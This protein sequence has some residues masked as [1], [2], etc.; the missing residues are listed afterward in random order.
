MARGSELPGAVA[1][2]LDVARALVRR[3]PSAQIALAR[4]DGV[5][6]AD[7]LGT[8][9]AS[10]AAAARAATCVPLDIEVVR[11]ELRAAW[12]RP[13]DGVLGDLDPEPLAVRPA[14]Q[15]HRATFDGEPV[16]VKVRRPGIERAVRSDL[17]LLDTLAG[18]LRAA[19]PRLDAGAVLRM[20]RE[21]VLDEL[22]LE[23][24]GGQQRRVARALRD[25]PGV[26]VP[27][28]IL[29][30]AAPEVLVTQLAAGRTLAEGG[31]PP[32][33][34]AAAASVMAAFRAACTGAGLAPVDPRPAH[35]VVA[36]DGALALLGLGVAWPVDRARAAGVF[37]AWDA[38]A[39]GD[40]AAFA[41]AVEELGLLEAADAGR[42]FALLRAVAGPLL[43]AG[44][45]EPLDGA[46]LRALRDRTAAAQ[47]D[48]VALVVR[49]RAQPGDL[50]LGRMA[51]QLAAVL[52][53]LE[54]GRGR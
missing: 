42:A 52:A 3:A 32:D 19:F 21:Q 16:A 45:Q 28:P 13:A 30:L 22:D 46:A 9:L 53:R 10:E 11:R 18:P 37:A 24:E 48:V 39:V 49:T 1:N 54:A 26:T 14:A 50:A 5:L 23:H 29:E 33:P 34:A 20:V 47:R 27:R 8:G 51:V 38:L 25:V 2:L 4:L 41:R 44:G 35:V 40:E 12:R 43:P 31:R 6:G 17:A 7:V 15:V 36:P